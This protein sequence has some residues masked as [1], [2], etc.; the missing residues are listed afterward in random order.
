MKH[1]HAHC[2]EPA[3]DY[4]IGLPVTNDRRLTPVYA[5]PAFSRARRAT[6]CMMGY[7]GLMSPLPIAPFCA[8][9]VVR[10]RANA[11]GQYSSARVFVISILR[12]VSAKQGGKAVRVSER[13]AIAS[14]STSS[15]WRKRA[16]PLGLERLMAEIGPSLAR[17]NQDIWPRNFHPPPATGSADELPKTDRYRTAS[18][19]ERA[20]IEFRTRPRQRKTIVT[21]FTLQTLF[22]FHATVALP[23]RVRSPSSFPNSYKGP[24]GAIP[25]RPSEAPLCHLATSANMRDRFALIGD[26]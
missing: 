26:I 1:R 2:C 24:T 11:A 10:C 14:A 13:A 22:F 3:C 4:T 20:R 6:G 12:R 9:S 18:G 16:R 21:G 19:C 7:N 25:R 23:K 17:H 8:C 15:T 5:S